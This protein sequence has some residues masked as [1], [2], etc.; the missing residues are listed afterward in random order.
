MEPI[1]F[2]LRGELDRE[3]QSRVWLNGEPLYPERSQ[4]VYN[5]SPDGFSWGYNGSGPAQLALA[6]LLELTSE[7]TAI[8]YYQMFKA[9]VIAALPVHENFAE[10]ELV[11]DPAEYE[12]QNRELETRLQS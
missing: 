6:I 4:R 12:Q 9:R 5:H 2:R 10:R 11:F 1:K 8:A 3:Y 7:T